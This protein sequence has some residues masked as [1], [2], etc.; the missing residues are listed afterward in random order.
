MTECNTP[1]DLVFAGENSKD[2]PK[3]TA[4]Q[5]MPYGVTTLQTSLTL[6]HL[7]IFSNSSD[8]SV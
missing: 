5:T 8:F 6:R 2:F 7:C 3:L 4:K 1:N